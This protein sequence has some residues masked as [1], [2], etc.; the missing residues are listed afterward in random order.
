MGNFEHGVWYIHY[1]VTPDGHHSA[2]NSGRWDA[3]AVGF[4]DEDGET[5]DMVSDYLPCY[6]VAVA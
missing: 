1:T 2:G 6:C 3:D 5:V 4:F